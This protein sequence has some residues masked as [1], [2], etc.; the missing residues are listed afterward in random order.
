MERL[1]VWNKLQSKLVQGESI[2]QTLHFVVSTSAQ[3]GFV[4]QS[5]LLGDVVVKRA[6]EWAVP[7]ELYTPITQ[8]MVLLK[9]SMAE[10]AVLAFWDFMRTAEAAEVIRATGYDLPKSK[11]GARH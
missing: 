2:A 5:M 10:P 1:G 4:A 3:A 6:C 7:D 9:R 8:K 11:V